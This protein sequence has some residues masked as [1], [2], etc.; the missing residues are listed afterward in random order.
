M[1]NKYEIYTLSAIALFGLLLKIFMTKKISS[2]GLQG[3]ADST[4]YGYS[5]TLLSTTLLLIYIHWFSSK[6][7]MSENSIKSVIRLISNSLPVLV[8]ISVLIWSI[9]IHIK[10]KE[11]INKG[12]VLNDYNKFEIISTV[13]I[14]FQFILVAKYILDFIK[15]SDNENSTKTLYKS[16]LNNSL[17]IFGK[18][19]P[20][21]TYLF[22]VVNYLIL[23]II[24]VSLE[25]FSTD[26]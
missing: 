22:G 5:I 2:D 18:T 26:G 20:Y 9:V 3:P 15:L 7:I 16:I 1:S 19:L 17:D 23:G 6:Q 25:Y 21:F 4:I 12:K 11:R 10:F 14:I 24:Q 13:L 8:F